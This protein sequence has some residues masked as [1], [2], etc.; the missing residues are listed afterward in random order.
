MTTPEL[1]HIR[2]VLVGSASRQALERRA[3]IRRLALATAL[4]VTLLFGVV[5]AGAAGNGPLTSILRPAPVTT[6]PAPPPYQPGDKVWTTT[7]PDELPSDVPPARS[8]TDLPA[9]AAVEPVAPPPY[10]PG[11]RVWTTTPPAG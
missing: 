5:A 7:P 1:D 3:R 11:D 10:Q 8:D 9:Q 2:R 4:P 6:V